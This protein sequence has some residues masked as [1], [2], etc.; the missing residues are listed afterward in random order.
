M[1]LKLPIILD[2]NSN[3]FN[4]LQ[5]NYYQNLKAKPIMS[6]EL[7]SR[8]LEDFK[9]KDFVVLVHGKIRLM[10]LAHDLKEGKVKDERKFNFYIQKI[11][12][13]IE[14]LNEKELGLFNN[15]NFLLKSG[16]NQFYIDTEENLEQI[17]KIYRNL[18]DNKPA[19]FSS[20][21][22]NYVLGWNRQGTL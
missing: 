3:C 2:Y 13:G 1:N 7:S 18:L 17:L 20:L 19:S 9:N 14:V 5:L 22:K 12:N 6:L 8:E 15:V 10:T 16:I 21:K 4:D 11:F